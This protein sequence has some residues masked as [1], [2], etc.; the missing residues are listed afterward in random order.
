MNGKQLEESTPL[1]FKQAL[2]QI[3]VLWKDEQESKRQDVHKGLLKYREE[4]PKGTQY[5]DKGT[6]KSQTCSQPDQH[7]TV[8]SE[9]MG[10]KCSFSMC[11]CL[12][13]NKMACK[14]CAACSRV[15]F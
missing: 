8:M 3:P 10:L 12:K 7:R 11:H 6:D 4:V 1:R 15:R 13:L 5:T 14:G 2:H 9:V